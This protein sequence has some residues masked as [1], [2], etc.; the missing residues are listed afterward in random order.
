MLLL[1]V[2]L[3]WSLVAIHV[4]AGAVLFRRIFP[5]ESAWFGFIV[6]ALALCVGLNFIEHFIALPSL[7]LLLPITTLGSLFLLA[8]P[9]FDWAGLRARF[10]P[11]AAR[12]PGSAVPVPPFSWVDLWVPLTAFLVSFAYTFLVRCLNPST[13]ASS[14][15][16]SDL[17]IV[18]NF[19]H[20]ETL[21]PTDT[22]LPP[23]K[24]KFYYTFQ[25]YG[26]SVLTRL[27]GLDLGS[28]GNLSHALLSALICVAAAAAA[29]RLTG[30]AWIA[31]LMPVL[32]EG[33]ATGSSAYLWLTERDPSPW[34]M[35]DLS[36][37]LDQPDS[38]PIWKLLATA[39]YPKEM[40]RLQVPGFWTYRDE[41]HPNAGGHFFTLVA[42]WLLF[43]LLRPERRNWPWIGA[44]LLP[45]L[46]IVTSTWSLPITVL[47]AGGGMAVAWQQKR[48]PENGAFAWGTA[49]LGLV[50]LW[51]TLMPLMIS[52]DAPPIMWT[53]PEWRTPFWE[54]VIQWWPIFILWASLVV[55]WCK[56]P[57]ELKWAL[58]AVPLLLIA[59]ELITIE[60]GRYNTIEKMWG[61][62][63]G[64]GLVAF[65]PAVAMRRSVGH[66]LVAALVLTSAVI[67]LCGWVH[68]SL[69]WVDWGKNAWHLE[70]DGILRLDPQ[71][72][73]ILQVVSQLHN[74]TELPGKV[75]WD[76]NDSPATAVFSGNRCYAAWFYSE[77]RFGHKGEAD[78]RTQ[79]VND[80]YAGKLPDPLGFLLGHDIA[81]VV[82]WPDDQI[83]DA[84]LATFKQQLGAQYD[85]TDCKGDGPNNAGV[86]LRRTALTESAAA[87][88]APAP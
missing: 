82:I 69:R 66:R 58:V 5:R 2:L 67:S 62:V 15:G 74:A 36:G 83:P 28:G 63:F 4:A 11:A 35:A 60:D 41:Y 72:D 23:F 75:V 6:P 21:P 84:Q 70:A 22:W 40:L 88:R 14:D 47:V 71:R 37:G 52:P 26:A 85:Y 86:F 30:R 50:C 78:F 57:P 18:G 43:E 31:L 45:F 61:S 44:A 16:L 20:G 19:L 81:A 27:L 80:F 64:V 25:H 46:T 9:N 55:V 79:Q 1:R 77:E 54:F 65:F 8:R 59:I 76:Y 39:P 13:L 34:V 42:V 10:Q 53:K 3:L 49:A 32:I 73:R 17:N 51:P 56:L 38:N 68:D 7:L 87:D 48:R 33:A 29:W 24:L 12:T